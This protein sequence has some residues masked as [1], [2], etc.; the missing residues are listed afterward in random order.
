MLAT[1]ESISMM[2]LCMQA[3]YL[4]FHCHRWKFERAEFAQFAISKTE[5]L[6]EDFRE[7]GNLLTDIADI[8][9]QSTTTNS[10]HTPSTAGDLITNFL[11]SRFNDAQSSG[12]N[13]TTQ[14]QREIHK[15][16]SEEKL[17]EVQESD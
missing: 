2:L 16:F 5:E 1:I 11:I 6:T 14:E 8:L 13:G 12:N 17:S 7:F 9:D 4:T 15:E 10:N 3:A